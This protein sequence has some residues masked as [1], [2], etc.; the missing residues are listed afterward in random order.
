[1]TRQV[2]SLSITIEEG[3]EGLSIDR[4]SPVY[5]LEGIRDGVVSGIYQVQSD[6]VQCLG[7]KYFLKEK[8]P[9]PHHETRR[10][11]CSFMAD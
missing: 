6:L 1:M 9:P 11:R 8:I 5:C 2:T 10:V 4:R 3:R 7:R